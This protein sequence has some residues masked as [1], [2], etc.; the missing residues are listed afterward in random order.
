V[1]LAIVVMLGS[2]AWADMPWFDQQDCDDLCRARLADR[3]A[4]EHASALQLGKLAIRSAHDRDC[5]CAY[6]LLEAS[7]QRDNVIRTAV[8]VDDAVHTCV[9]DVP[10]S[11]RQ[12]L[13]EVSTIP[14]TVAR[15][16]GDR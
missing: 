2:C 13:R 14:G 1:K 15:C 16:I 11:A 9:V 8:L 4:I 12:S 5:T 10:P 3:D 6:A 7:S